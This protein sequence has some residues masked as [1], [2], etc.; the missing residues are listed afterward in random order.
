[1]Y[2]LDRRLLSASL[3]VFKPP[4]IVGATFRCHY[5]I[6]RSIPRDHVHDLLQSQQHK[7]LP[8]GESV[9]PL[10][11]LFHEQRSDVKL[12]SSTMIAN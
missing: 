2:R 5:I 7:P 9:Q 10:S 11:L 1:M 8:E 6:S 3:F 12:Q 4:S